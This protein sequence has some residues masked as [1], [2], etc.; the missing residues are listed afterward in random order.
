MSGIAERVTP[1]EV[2]TSPA[3]P[4][5]LYLHVPFCSDMDVYVDAL[6]R[7]AEMWAHHRAFQRP[8][9][10]SVFV[11]G[12]PSYLPATLFHR[13]LQSALRVFDVR[14]VQ[15]TAESNPESID[16]DKLH[17]MKDAGVTRLSIHRQSDITRSVKQAREVFD[18][19]SIDLVYGAQTFDAFCDDL[20]RA[21]ELPITHI[22]FVPFIG[23]RNGDRARLWHMYDHA[24]DR[25]EEAGFAQYTSEDFTRSGVL[26]RY[27]TDVWE[28]PVKATLGLGVGALSGFGAWTWHDI[29][30][31]PEYIRAVESAIVPIESGARMS[32]EQRR[33]DHILGGLHTLAVHPDRFEKETGVSLWRAFGPIPHALAVAGLLRH[34]EDGVW[35]PTR[36]G[37]FAVSH[38][39]AA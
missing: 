26:C 39:L 8:C 3:P 4:F 24:L 2:V 11:G 33:L 9:V 20:W 32:K 27:Q 15:V 35:T 13:M 17:A 22:S 18:E 23:K 34:R 10:T 6:V 31:V 14:D 16:I 19:V 28:P 38:A 12:A 30:S 7:E 37:R 5:A 21:I 25:L 36:I 1:D 29:G